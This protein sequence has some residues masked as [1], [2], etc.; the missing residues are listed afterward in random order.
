MTGRAS[1][2][3]L[4]DTY[5][6]AQA[7]ALRSTEHLGDVLDAVGSPATPFPSDSLSQQLQQVARVVK[8]REVRA[9]KCP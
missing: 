9:P 8:A 6:A 3:L 5:A 4:A 2:S 1:T 7:E